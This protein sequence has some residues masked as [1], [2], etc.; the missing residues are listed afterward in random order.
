[1]LAGVDAAVVVMGRGLVDPE[2][3]C[4]NRKR[5][6]VLAVDTEAVVV[7]AAGVDI[8]P[9]VKAVGRSVAGAGAAGDVEP[10]EGND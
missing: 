6:T 9:D 7:A 8:D 2:T 3:T 5:G 1:M 10:T 4:L